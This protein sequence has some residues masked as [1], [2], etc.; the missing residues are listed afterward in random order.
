VSTREAQLKREY[1]DWYPGV[2]AGV[3]LA[4]EWVAGQVLEQLRNG[5]P[6][7]ELSARALSDD[8]FVFRGG[9]ADRPSG[10]HTRVS[11]IVS[12]GQEPVG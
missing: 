4:A 12:L 5:E 10:S 11:D 6:R 7:W 3:W 1:A 2:E 9:M 8:H